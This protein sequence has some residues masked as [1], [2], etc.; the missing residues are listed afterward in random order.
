MTVSEGAK[1]LGG[2]IAQTGE[3]DA[4]GHQK[5]GGSAEH[6]RGDVAHHIDVLG[7]LVTN[8]GEQPLHAVGT[9]GDRE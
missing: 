9:S 8:D 3:A 7:R 1:P 6:H 2:E 4:Y 5:L